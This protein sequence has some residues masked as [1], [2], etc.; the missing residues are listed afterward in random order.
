MV[1]PEYF[2][3][4][5]IGIVRGRPF[6]GDDGPGGRP[7]AIVNERL[8]GALWP[9]RDPIGRRFS[10]HGPSGPWLEVV[11]LTR[12]GKYH[13]LFEEPQPY[14]YVPM[15]QQPSL[16]RVL[17]VRTS[18]APES[19]TDMVARVVRRREPDLPLYGVESM[20]TALDGGY[21]FFLVRV[22]AAAIAAFGGLGLALATIGI[23]GVVSFVTGQRTRE[24]GVR[25]AL[26]A[27]PGDI[28]WLV[29]R[30]GLILT[31][32]GIGVGLAV[33]SAVAPWI[34]AFL[35]G[36]SARDPLTLC[37]VIVVVAS[38]ATVA[39]L[40]PGWRAIRVDPTEALRAE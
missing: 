7:V 32:V 36:V 35:F 18:A 5:G 4:M 28:L 3:T 29:L 40:V 24:I 38:T 22:A 10:E 21:G 33:A 34:G 14:F 13:L 23:Y 15:A 37:G 27:G 30:D 26:G 12:T 9:G 20:A 31:A 6:T 8:A 2:A 19:L 11:G 17:Q 1:T 39:S 25:I 16:M